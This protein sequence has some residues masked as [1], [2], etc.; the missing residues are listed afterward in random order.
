MLAELTEKFTGDRIQ[1][2]LDLEVHDV[3]RAPVT[4]FSVNSLP[5]LFVISVIFRLT[6]FKIVK[7][8]REVR[9]SRLLTTLSR[10]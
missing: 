4:Y 5:L 6:S 7:W 1:A 8:L 2:L 3:I 10:M 9:A